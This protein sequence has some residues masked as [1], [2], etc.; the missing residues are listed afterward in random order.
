MAV[1]ALPELWTRLL[2]ALRRLFRSKMLKAETTVGKFTDEWLALGAD[3]LLICEGVLQH[4]NFA[5]EGK[6]ASNAELC[7]I[8]DDEAISLVDARGFKFQLW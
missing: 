6:N 5:E 8:L 3:L 2:Y 7:R 1:A 4:A